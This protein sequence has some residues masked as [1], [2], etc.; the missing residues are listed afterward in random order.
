MRDSARLY[1]LRPVT[2]A[3]IEYLEAICPS[4]VH[5]NVDLSKL[6]RWKIGGIADCIVRPANTEQLASTIR[7]FKA[8]D[9]P[10]VV[11]GATSNLLF[12][13][14]GLRVPCIQIGS[15]M[16]DLSIQGDTVYAEA[17]VWVP[18]LARRIMQAGLTGAEHI[19]GIPGTLGG[20]LC[21]NG[22]SQRK[23]IGSSV[24]SIES[25][26]AMG[27]IH[28]R[29]AEQCEFAYR[30]SVY[31]AN[32]EIITAAKLRFLPDEKKLIR[33]SMLNILA[34]RNKKFPRKLPNC[35]SVFKSNPAMYD[36]IGPPGAAIERLGFKGH[37][38][39][40]ALV[41]PMHANFIVNSGEA[42]ATDV[43]KLIKH[44]SAAVA[45][46][47]GH[48]MQ[49]EARFVSL[50]GNILPVDQVLNGAML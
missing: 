32:R 22:G 1:P 48:Y 6:S 44:I 21:M 35:G 7:L 39:G 37:R 24:V 11:I 16:S 18:G 20:L 23:G 49:A 5:L 47:T 15:R 34:E 50:E 33:Q 41:S 30:S 9:V 46:H 29:D 43:L 2:P 31:Q 40:G 45:G 8:Q 19:C 14:E 25:V 17:G 36:D 13:D 26:D 3:L 28:Y 27:K 12:A 10:Y 42:S 38:V 4:G